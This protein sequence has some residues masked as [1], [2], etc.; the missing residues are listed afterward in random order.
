[1]RRGTR[2]ASSGARGAAV[3]G[4]REEAVHMSPVDLRALIAQHMNPKDF[5]ALM[6]ETPEFLW[7]FFCRGCSWSGPWCLDGDIDS[8]VG[9][10]Q[11]HARLGCCAPEQNLALRRR[12]Y[13]EPDGGE[14]WDG[15][16]P[17]GE[18][19]GEP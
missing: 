5:R 4:A 6:L 3:K 8:L 7:R 12:R 9:S 16:S 10:W 17:Y 1:M 15:G 14:N 18:S 19:T 2:L 11:A 13:P